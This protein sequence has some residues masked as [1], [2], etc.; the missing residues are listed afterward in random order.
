MTQEHREKKVALDSSNN[1][2]CWW[3]YQFL[4]SNPNRIIEKKDWVIPK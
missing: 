2:K 3:V 4:K 1:G